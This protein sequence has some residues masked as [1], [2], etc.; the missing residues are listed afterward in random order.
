MKK[1]VTRE[2]WER[3]WREDAEA[4]RHLAERIA[5]HRAKLE[6]ERAAKQQ[7]ESPSYPSS[8]R[9]TNRRMPP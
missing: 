5:Y 8:R 2:E 4:Q 1:K 9:T 3:F 6:E 7:R